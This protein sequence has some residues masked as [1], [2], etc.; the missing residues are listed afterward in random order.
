MIHNG[1]LSPCPCHSL[2]K[3]HTDQNWTTFGNEF[4]LGQ[5][6][7]KNKKMCDL[8]PGGFEVNMF[9]NMAK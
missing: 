1:D 5:V 8:D 7:A 4:R 2:Q 3:Y 6:K 9:T